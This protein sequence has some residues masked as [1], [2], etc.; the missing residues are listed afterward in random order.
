MQI[1]QHV[2]S[3]S[4]IKLL[5][6]PT[7]LE[8]LRILIAREAS[9]SQI[10]STINIHPARVRHH[11]K[12]LEKEGLVELVSVQMEKNYL[13]KYYRATANMFVVNMAVLSEPPEDDHLVVLASDDPALNFLVARLNSKMGGNYV[14]T[15]PVGSLDALIYLKENFSDIAGCHL[16]DIATG[17]YNVPYVQHLFSD[18]TMAIVKFVD[19]QQGFYVKK[20]NPQN[21]SGLKDLLRND[22]KFKNRKRGTGTRLWIDQQLKQLNIKYDA[23]SIS[24]PDAPTH[25]DVAKAVDIGLATTGIGV[26]SIAQSFDLDFIP[27]FSEQF[28]LVMREETYLSS[29]F[30]PVIEILKDQ[31]FKELIIK[32]GGYS[33][34]KM[35]QVKLI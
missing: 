1:I 20:G 21:I 8:I 4:A 18:Q 12:L 23:I 13:V 19:R 31:L 25:S 3:D 17:E 32:M 5:G 14:Y 10:G 22:V 26:M 2:K 27:L 16:Y 30:E 24:T 11:I 34:E 15:L 28:D 33:V 6:D 35:G 9:L 7:R 29:R